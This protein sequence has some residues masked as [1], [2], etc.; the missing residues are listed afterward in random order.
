MNQSDSG[1]DTVNVIIG[2]APRCKKR[3]L[4]TMEQTK[5]ERGLR[6]KCLQTVIWFDDT[7]CAFLAHNNIPD[8]IEAK[9]ADE[10]FHIDKCLLIL[11]LLQDG[12]V[13]CKNRRGEMFIKAT[14]ELQ[15]MVCEQAQDDPHYW[16]FLSLSAEE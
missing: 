13:K 5:N 10:Q 15:S 4:T 6:L 12:L 7:V 1:I 2:T 14:K 9:N 11:S 3:R 8:T 16:D